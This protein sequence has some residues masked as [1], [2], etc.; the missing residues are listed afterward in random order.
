MEADWAAEIGQDLP[1][2]TVPWNVSGN[3]LGNTSGEGFI[4]LR[5]N[6]AAIY[7]IPEA[8]AHP[9][10]REALITLNSS[11]SPLFTAKCDLW[12]LSQS[13]IDPDEFASS[14]EDAH[15]GTAS[16]IDVLCRDL[17]AFASFE[18]HER[19]A[20]RL[21]DLLRPRDLSN[22]RVEI[23]LRPSL[24]DEHPGFGL[25][26]YAAGCGA[27]SIEAHNAWQTVLSAAVAATISAVSLP[28]PAGE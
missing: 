21:T 8:A 18:F 24:V 10:L 2:I 25:T 15:H 23:V 19:C 3:V 13:E 5:Q 7:G 27:S 1:C 14:P 16:Y 28:P 12:T 4:D 9:A 26:L 11:A 17:T 6:S 22:G 20:R